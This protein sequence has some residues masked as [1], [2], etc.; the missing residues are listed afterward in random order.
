MDMGVDL[1]G[2]LVV[3]SK[4]MGALVA[5]SGTTHLT[6]NGSQDAPMSHI[7]S[8]D[9]HCT[10]PQAGIVDHSLYRPLLSTVKVKPIL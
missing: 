9:L 8:I 4:N 10:L 3:V 1:V 5:T 7:V 2:N 6:S